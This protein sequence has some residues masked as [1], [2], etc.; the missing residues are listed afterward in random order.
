MYYCISEFTS[1]TQVST[2]RLSSSQFK[3]KLR[4]E[5]MMKIEKMRTFVEYEGN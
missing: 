2:V 4:Y 5:S 1:S 3:G